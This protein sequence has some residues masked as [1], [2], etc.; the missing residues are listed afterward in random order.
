VLQIPWKEELG[1]GKPK[2]SQAEKFL[3]I[4]ETSFYYIGI[5]LGGELSSFGH[6]IHFIGKEGTHEEKE[7]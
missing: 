5:H 3:D 4:D 6:R 7:R 1:V 2:N